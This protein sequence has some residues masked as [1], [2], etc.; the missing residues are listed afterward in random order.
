MNVSGVISYF[1]EKLKSNTSDSEKLFFVLGLILFVSFP[2]FYLVNKALF[3]TDGY[4]N[5]ELRIII[6]MLGIT[7]SL[8]KYW[9]RVAVRYT[10]LIFHFIIFISFPFF[11]TLML[12]HNPHSAVWHVNSLAGLILLSFF[13]DYVIFCVMTVS[14]LIICNFLVNDSFSDPII[15]SILSSYSAP[16][17]YFIIFSYK[18][19]IYYEEIDK[20]L[21]IKTANLEKALSA[22]SYFLSNLSHEIRSPIQGFTSITEGLVEHW[23]DFSEKYRFLLVKK[24][25]K[26][27]QRLVRIVNDIL[28]LSRFS[29]NKMVFSFNY[30]NISTL[31]EEIIEE[32][33]CLYLYSKN[34]RIAFVFKPK[35]TVLCYIDRDRMGQVIR[36]LLINAIKFSPP[37]TEI[38]ISLIYNDD[39]VLFSISD[40]G[41]GIT[42]EDIENIFIPFFQSYR[43]KNSEY[44]NGLG[45]AICKKII[46]AH[47]GKIWAM[48]NIDRGA[49]FLFSIPI[50]KIDL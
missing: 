46:E 14:A 41:S 16:I 7:L 5:I 28:D 44:G 19:R 2:F 39:E 34:I 6:A 26:N 38:F 13:V 12:F 49:S 21:K 37:K 30:H 35:K 25:A 24:I 11:F 1:N 18:R 17:I 29:A 45:L 20:K 42:E 8:H 10:P 22:K 43:T 31:I 40:E 23:S 15:K 3:V 4:E 47:N 33:K 48:N 9:P 36:N 32:A 50:L 27:S